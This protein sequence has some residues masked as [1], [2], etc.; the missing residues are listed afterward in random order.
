MFTFTTYDAGATITI[1]ETNKALQPFNASGGLQVG[2]TSVDISTTTTTFAGP[3]T[4]VTLPDGVHGQIKV[5]TQASS[6]AAVVT[7][8][9]PAWS[10]SL[11]QVTLTGQGSACTLLFTNSA[12]FCIGQYGC[13]F[14]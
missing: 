11:K 10:G 5:L 6:G 1:T 14:A 4:G 3:I 2:T 9:S 8:T 7:V 12:W 13:T